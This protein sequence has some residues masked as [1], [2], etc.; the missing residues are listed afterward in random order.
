VIYAALGAFVHWVL[1]RYGGGVEGGLERFVEELATAFKPLT[2]VKMVAFVS[3]GS[4]VSMI[5]VSPST[6]RQALA[7]GMAW[8]TL[9]SRLT[10]ERGPP[11]RRG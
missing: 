10:S 8:T 6:A 9:L 5:M 1:L 4:A 11:R 2:V 7:A 3:L